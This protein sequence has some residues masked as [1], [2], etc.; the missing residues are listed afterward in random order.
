MPVFCA[1]CDTEFTNTTLTLHRHSSGHLRLKRFL[2]P[3][4]ISCD[5]EFPTRIDWDEHLLSTSHIKKIS[6][7]GEKINILI[8]SPDQLFHFC[9]GLT[10]TVIIQESSS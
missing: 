7:L 5:Q 4:C 8:H 9:M 10:N 6:E 1:M 2:H 3:K